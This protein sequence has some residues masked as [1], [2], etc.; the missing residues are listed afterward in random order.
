MQPY[1]KERLE[2]VICFLASEHQKRTK[3]PLYQTSLYKYLAFFEVRLL[4]KT[5]QLPLGLR[6]LAMERGPVPEEL[7]SNRETIQ[8]D[9]FRFIPEEGGRYRVQAIGK[10]DLDYLSDLEVEELK[11]LIE[12]FGQRWIRTKIMS[13]ASHQDIV[14][15]KKAYSKRPNT[16]IDFKDEFPDIEKKSIEELSAAEERF[17]MEQVIQELNEAAWT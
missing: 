7:Y 16:T 14:S 4:R 12:I 17:L 11:N 10:Q 6:Y 5:G 3:E 2:N 9:K 13:D 1:F 8:S 15:W